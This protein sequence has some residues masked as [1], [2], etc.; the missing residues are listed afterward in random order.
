MKRLSWMSVCMF[1]LICASGHA[2][3]RMALTRGGLGFLFADHNS[4]ANAGNF[5]LDKGTA[6]E[7]SY[8]QFKNVPI[9]AAQPSF[10]Y[11]SG[12]V[13][14]GLYGQRIATSLSDTNAIDSVG[15]G[16]GVTLAKDRVTLGVYGSRSLA[17][18]PTSDGT[19]GATFT[20]NGNKRVGFSLG[21]AVD[22]TLNATNGDTKSGRAAI[23]W[24][25]NTNTS[26]EAVATLNDIE[27]TEDVNLAGYLNWSGQMF[28]FSGGVIYNKLLQTTSVAGR[29]GLAF[30]RFDVSGFTTMATESGGEM[31]YGGSARLAF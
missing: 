22:T 1:A 15:G 12:K 26:I 27:N 29:A 10:V 19:V 24:G 25:F 11:G 9:V 7:V 13:G 18:T 17:T 20:L 8:G 6:A 5:A 3:K 31:F 21:G 16:L 30:G 4:F 23:G 2:E 28:Y 14:F